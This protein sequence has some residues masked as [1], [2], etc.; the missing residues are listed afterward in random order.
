MQ[1]IIRAT[2]VWGSFQRGVSLD[3][4]FGVLLLLLF[5]YNQEK[6]KEK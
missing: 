3:P 4:F 1:T 2:L 6:Y 5:L